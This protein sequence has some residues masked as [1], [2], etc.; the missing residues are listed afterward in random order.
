MNSDFASLVEVMAYLIGGT[1][2][3][4]VVVG[5]LLKHFGTRK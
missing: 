2:A 3:I 1:V 4:A 5:W